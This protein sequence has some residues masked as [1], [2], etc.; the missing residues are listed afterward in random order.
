MYANVYKCLDSRYTYLIF[1]NYELS[2]LC[3]FSHRCTISI[4]LFYGKLT[5]A[6]RKQWII[7]CR[8]VM[9]KDWRQDV[10]PG[11]HNGHD[12]DGQ[13]RSW[14]RAA[15]ARCFGSI[16]PIQL[17]QQCPLWNLLGSDGCGRI[18]PSRL[19]SV[20]TGQKNVQ[21]SSGTES[22]YPKE[23]GRHAHRDL[24]RTARSAQTVGHLFYLLFYAAVLFNGHP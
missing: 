13:C 2:Y 16:R 22:A 18:L 4:Y 5:K 9:S 12:H 10:T 24:T 14:R 17:P 8:P 23:I 7:Y 3:P 21:P 15:S 1:V 20:H 11:K 19:S 6:P